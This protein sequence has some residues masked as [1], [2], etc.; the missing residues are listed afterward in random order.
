VRDRPAQG[1]RRAQ[2]KAGL[3]PAFFVAENQGRRRR[4]AMKAITPT[5]A[6]SSA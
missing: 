3:G 4:A 2:Q 1:E 6:S 5:P